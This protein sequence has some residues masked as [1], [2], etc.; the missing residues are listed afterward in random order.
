MKSIKILTVGLLGLLSSCA[1]VDVMVDKS[2]LKSETETH[3]IYPSSA[4]TPVANTDAINARIKDSLTKLKES[5]KKV[6]NQK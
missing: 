1:T 4:V 6:I 5:K 3:A 2:Q